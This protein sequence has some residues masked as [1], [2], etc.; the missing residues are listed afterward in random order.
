MNLTEKEKRL[1]AQFNEI[2]RSAGP[3]FEPYRGGQVFGDRMFSL[4]YA[5]NCEFHY[6][7]RV[8][9]DCIAVLEKGIDNR[10]SCILLHSASGSVDDVVSGLYEMFQAAKLPL[11]FEYVCREELPVYRAAAAAMGREARI[12]SREEDSD[13]VYQTQDFVSLSGKANKGKRGDRNVLLREYPDIHMRCYDGGNEEIKEDCEKIFDQWC[14]DRE[15]RECFYGCEKTACLRFFDIFDQKYHRI[16]ASYAQG[17]PLSFAISER[18]S[19][20]TVCYY[21]QKNA[22]RIRGL[23]YWLNREMALLHPDA[24]WINLGEDMGLPGLRED[25]RGLHPF[26]KREKYFVEIR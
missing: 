7:Y 12:A 17:E 2:D 9:G 23:T 1:F 15:C 3:L 22:R 25:K 8:M 5:W 11:Y 21:F 13:Y 16:A 6:G 10:L 26:G 14:A 18:I 4:I 19:P 20:D 24:R